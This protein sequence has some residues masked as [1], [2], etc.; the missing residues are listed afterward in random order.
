MGTYNLYS[1]YMRMSQSSNPVNANDT[2]D[3]VDTN[4]G[5]AQLNA[6]KDITNTGAG[7]LVA[8]TGTF[9]SG[10]V[11]VATGLTLCTSFIATMIGTGATASGATEIERAVVAS[12]ATGAVVVNG[13]YHSGSA[14]ISVQSVSGTGQFYYLAYGT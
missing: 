1:R 13:S 11:T 8:G 9:V 6:V 12:I 5:L 10:T 14:A 2:A 7:K 4:Q 3:L